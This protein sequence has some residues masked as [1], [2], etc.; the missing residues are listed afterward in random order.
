VSS[1][2]EVVLE[3]ARQLRVAPRDDEQ[4]AIRWARQGRGS[5]PTDLFAR[6]GIREQYRTRRARPRT[7]S[8]QR[9]RV[10]GFGVSAWHRG[11]VQ[12]AESAFVV[13]PLNGWPGSRAARG[14]RLFI[15]RPTSSCG[16][17]PGPR[18]PRSRG[19]AHVAD[20]AEGA[21]VHGGGL[22]VHDGT[23]W[24]SAG[25]RTTRRCGRSL[26]HSPTSI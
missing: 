20:L 22:S 9:P 23:R 25:P 10:I 1:P 15:C 17:S 13:P 2:V 26:R 7:Y 12:R 8:R 4:E 24:Q 5:T 19:D 6:R 14:K 16:S 18:T 3:V 21:L 11:S